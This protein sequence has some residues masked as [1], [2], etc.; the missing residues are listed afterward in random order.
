MELQAD[1]GISDLVA[2]YGD[3]YRKRMRDLPI[4]N[5]RLDVEAVGFSEVGDHCL[6]VL[7]TPWFMN[8]V[9]LP[10]T[11]EWHDSRTGDTATITLPDGDYEF[12][13]SQDD[14]L[15][16]YLTAVLFRTVTDFPNQTTARAIAA[17]IL[18]ELLTERERQPEAPTLSRRA[19]LSG[20]G[21][22]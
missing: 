21:A 11:D 13:V 22:D 1:I 15:G 9:I 17:E 19:L 3:V 10:G 18:Q 7:I 8:L 5:A 14:A 2:Y 12:T 20:E 16:V 6:G 4:V